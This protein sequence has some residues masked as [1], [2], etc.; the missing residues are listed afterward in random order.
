M[1]AGLGGLG[2]PVA[3][4]LAVAG[5]GKLVL[6]DNGKVEESNLNRQL[7]YDEKDVGGWKVDVAKAR[8]S[9]MNSQI[10]IETGKEVL[11]SQVKQVDVVADCLDNWSARKKL[12]KMA[13]KHGKTV[14]H[15]A[16]DGFGGQLAFL[17]SEEDG[18][19]IMGKDGKKEIQVLGASVGIIGSR[20]AREIIEILDRGKPD[21]GWFMNFDG[22]NFNRYFMKGTRFNKW[23]TIIVRFCELWLKSK[24]TKRWMTKK[25]VNNIKQ[26]IPDADI[27]VHEGR[28]GVSPYSNENV[29][30]LRKVF[31]VKSI[32]PAVRISLDELDSQ[33][34]E[35]AKQTIFPGERFRV[36]ARRVNKG[37]PM[38]SMTLQKE[39]G[40]VVLEACPGSRVNLTDYDHNL[41]VEI[42][43]DFAFIFTQ[44]LPGPG[45]M[46]YGVE[47]R[48]LA[49]FSG[50]IDSP[51]AAWMAAKRGMALD[52][53][54]LNPLGEVLESRVH[55]VYERVRDWFP[56]S[57]FFVIDTDEIVKQIKTNVREGERQ[58]VLKRFFYRL[59]EKIA[60][61]H[62]YGALVTGESIGQASSQTMKSLGLIEKS[63]NILAIRP[64]VGM[65]KEETIKI[66]N[67]IGSFE[68]S[69]D[70]A[71]FCSIESHSN[72]SPDEKTILEEE[73][74][75]DINLDELVKS[76]RHIKKNQRVVFEKIPLPKSLEGYVVIDVMKKKAYE[77]RKG[78]KY[79]FVCRAANTAAE[80][81]H[82]ARKRGFEAHAMTYNRA[83]K[84][85][86]D[87]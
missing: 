16:V 11:E 66:A 27:K 25:F 8:L 77:L 36:T 43:K 57:K 42:H 63:V 87:L 9:G 26:T 22:E 7:L 15:G 72:A 59:A 84:M 60:N 47:G 12:W 14:V 34:V 38:S 17:V 19:K 21:T 70:F 45:G 73:T 4:Y 5:V 2:S 24:T 10:K 28:I 52:F 41:E 23:N 54:F 31:G 61:L 82:K 62:N 44:S 51:V 79:I 58:V 86:V 30:A 1:I 50:G 49:L 29:E 39:L 75:L 55:Q 67:R 48:G 56:D 20:M 40:A 69:T 33:F 85:G 71:E 37:F 83:R 78:K 6:V 74:K 76:I 65:D 32:N 18:E 35:I 3:L 81:A 13:F 64:L 46:P 80:A 68:A 53:L